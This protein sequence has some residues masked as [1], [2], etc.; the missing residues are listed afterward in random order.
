MPTTS[1]EIVNQAIQMMGDNQ[2]AVTGQYPSFDSSPAGIALN[3]IYGPCVQTVGRQHGWD[4]ARHTIALTPSA[5]TPPVDWPYEYLYPTNG[6][7]VWQIIPP[8]ISDPND[9]LPVNWI[10][11]NNIIGGQ[12]QRVIHTSVQNALARYNNNPNEN[13]WD[14][15]FREA[16][17]R[18]LA[19]ELLLAIAGR[20]ESSQLMLQS[21]GA[22]ETIGEGRQG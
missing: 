3:K 20:P 6:I 12:Q 9:P 8:T 4:M 21:G 17:A 18:L 1:Q 5:Q 13:T 22:F 7:Q 2:P 16:V 14:A 11:A 10:V 15:L 19:S